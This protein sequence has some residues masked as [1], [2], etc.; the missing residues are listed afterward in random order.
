MSYIKC[1]GRVQVRAL[2][3]EPEGQ[4]R[5]PLE[6]RA[7][8]EIVPFDVA[9]AYLVAVYVAP[10][11]FPG[12][13]DQFGRP[14]TTRHFRVPIVLY[15]YPVAAPAAEGAVD[16]VGVG[17]PAVRAELRARGR[18][19]QVGQHQAGRQVVHEA[20]GSGPG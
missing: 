7:D 18:V 13:A 6:E 1:D 19:E 4:P 20:F 2:L 11:H 14:V 16:G 15:Q 17:P 5:E 3:A 8:C 12:D 9:G 10:D